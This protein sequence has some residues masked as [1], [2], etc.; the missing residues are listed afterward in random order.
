MF[1]HAT[2]KKSIKLFSLDNDL[3]YINF[4]KLK[5]FKLC[6][7]FQNWKKDSYI[8]DSN[9]FQQTFILQNTRFYNHGFE[10]V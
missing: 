8:I 7:K 4:S 10:E 1:L 6:V 5:K 3:L 9:I 2:N